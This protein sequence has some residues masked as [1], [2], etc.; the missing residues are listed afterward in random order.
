MHR[1]A[2]RSGDYMNTKIAGLSVSLLVLAGCSS[3][4]G[5]VAIPDPTAEVDAQEDFTGRV[6]ESPIYQEIIGSYNGQLQ[7]SEGDRLCVWDTTVSVMPVESDDQ[8]CEIEG[9][10]ASTLLQQGPAAN[11]PYVCD[12]GVRDVVFVNGLAVG[13][14][15]T[16][17]RPVDLGFNFF[18]SLELLDAAGNEIVYA[19]TQFEFGVID[20]DELTTENGTFDKQ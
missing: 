13:D 19:V 7:F 6:C 20:I 5:S 15:L 11:I 16:T 4:G 17:L 8:N 12:S 14:D 10:I 9:T 2:V 18:P 1:R 3:G